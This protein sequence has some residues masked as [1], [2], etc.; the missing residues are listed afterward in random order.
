M[1]EKQNI[2]DFTEERFR[3]SSAGKI[4][5]ACDKIDAEIH[6][7][8]HVDKIPAHEVLVA[9]AHRLGIFLGTTN[10][11]IDRVA[12]KFGEV[13]KNAAKSQRNSI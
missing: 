13:I 8:L 6:Q 5:S 12:M 2:V 1:S 4:C 11:D 7:L 9:V 10:A 3:R